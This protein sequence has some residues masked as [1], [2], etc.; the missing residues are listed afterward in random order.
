MDSHCDDVETTVDHPNQCC[1]CNQICSKKANLNRHLRNVHGINTTRTSPG[2]PIS[3]LEESC[4][5]FCKDIATLRE[6]LLQEHNIDM[7]VENVKFQSQKG[8]CS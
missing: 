5:F 1:I 8:I 4:V 2:N 6:H 7:E 3:C